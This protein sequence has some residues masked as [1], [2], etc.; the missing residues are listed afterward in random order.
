MRNLNPLFEMRTLSQLS[1]S[2]LQMLADR[3]AS[4]QAAFIKSGK[5]LPP[6][7]Y[8][9]KGM[10]GRLNAWGV[11]AKGAPNDTGKF[12]YAPKWW[13]TSTP[14]QKVKWLETRRELDPDFRRYLIDDP[15]VQEY[16]ISN[17]IRMV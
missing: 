12:L 15:E 10:L 8:R 13:E 4:K 5:K 17:G 3:I 2:E 9:Q 7:F 11:T 6:K 14:K 16:L 1:R